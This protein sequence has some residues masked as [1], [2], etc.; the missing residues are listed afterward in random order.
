[1]TWL[2]ISLTVLAA[3]LVGSIPFGLLVGRWVKGIDIRE[4]GSRNI[5]ATNAARVLGTPWF[6]VVLVLDALKGAVPCIAA[7]LLSAHAGVDLVIAAAVGAL[8]GHFFS[9]YLRFRGGKGVATGL[10]VVLV[11]TALPAGS[12]APGWPLPALC[13]VLVF[14]AALWLTRIV[15]VSSIVAALSVPALYLV[16]L[17]AAALEPP[18]LW[19]F[20]FL[21]AVAVFVVIKHRGN[22][23]RVMRGQEPRLGDKK[24][25]K[26]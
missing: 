19:R 8:L 5:G 10:G 2:W 15:S 20:L 7:V 14:G 18:L 25:A 21:V 11:I 1:M 26:A 4:H 17:D 22:M 13:A 23:V 24:R 3:Y 16:W 6:F 12:L 9:I